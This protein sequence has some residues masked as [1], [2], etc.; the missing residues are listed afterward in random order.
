MA[1]YNLTFTF[2]ISCSQLSNLLFFPTIFGIHI[3][4][5]DFT[6]SSFSVFIILIC[7]CTINIYIYI[8]YI[9]LQKY[10]PFIF[11]RFVFFVIFSLSSLFACCTYHTRTHTNTRLDEIYNNLQFIFAPIQIST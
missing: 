8:K 5:Y 3:C 7:I 9:K 1:V 10:I 4:M 6:S 11:V 2:L